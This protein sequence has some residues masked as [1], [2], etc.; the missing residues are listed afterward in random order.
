[1]TKAD[2]LIER[3]KSRPA[4]FEWSELERMLV[5]FGYRVKNGDGSRRT[6]TGEGLPKIKL[7]EPH[8][9]PIVKQ[10]VLDQV[11]ELLEREQLI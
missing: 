11:R 7:H 8:P 10:Y 1:M 3:F 9:S 5:R 6:F 2:R 4:D